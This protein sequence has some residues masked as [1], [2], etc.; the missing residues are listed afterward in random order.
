MAGSISIFFYVLFFFCRSLPS[1]P[2]YFSVAF[3]FSL[4]VHLSYFEV[5]YVQHFRQLFLA[6]LYT[7]VCR[8][9]TSL[10][11]SLIHLL[12]SNTDTERETHTHTQRFDNGHTHS[13]LLF[14]INAA[15]EGFHF[16]W[17]FELFTHFLTEC[18]I[19]AENALQTK[20]N[21]IHSMA[22]QIKLRANAIWT[23]LM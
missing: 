21:S 7:H 6:F 19:T 14:V 23:H 8:C 13:C 2:F 15:V 11:T 4:C 17:A 10:V 12:Q 20:H 1:V 5:K 18:K 9:V 16:N 22:M 3:F